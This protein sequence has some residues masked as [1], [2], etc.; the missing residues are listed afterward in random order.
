[1]YKLSK[2]TE[3]C[4]WSDMELYF[5]LLISLCS[6]SADQTKSLTCLFD[7]NDKTFTKE[8]K[9]ALQLLTFLEQRLMAMWVKPVS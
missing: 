4:Y 6:L 8:K 3:S 2:Q 9:E 5:V 1:M 7:N